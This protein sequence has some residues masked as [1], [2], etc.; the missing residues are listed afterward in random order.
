[1]KML[2]QLCKEF[3][4]VKEKPVGGANIAGIL[5]AADAQSQLKVLSN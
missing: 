5:K 4:Q 1:M 2:Q 3:G